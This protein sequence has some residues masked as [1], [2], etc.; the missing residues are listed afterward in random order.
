MYARERQSPEFFCRSSTIFRTST[1]SSLLG[2]AA[3]GSTTETRADMVAARDAR[4]VRGRNGRRETVMGTGSPCA[5]TE[6]GHRLDRAQASGTDG[7]V[8]RGQP[9]DDGQEDHRL[10]QD[11]A[12]D[13]DEQVIGHQE[14]LH[15]DR[16]RYA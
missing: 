10:Q 14:E 6:V 7:R 1:S 8:E 5:S 12:V 16:D 11:G 15:P 9:A 4:L 13:Q 2:A 3:A